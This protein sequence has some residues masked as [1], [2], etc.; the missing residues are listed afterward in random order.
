MTNQ[1]K[2]VASRII[3][4]PSCKKTTRYDDSNEFRPFCCE[5]CQIID[6]G[7]WAD[8]EYR[9]PVKPSSDDFDTDPEG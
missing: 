2:Q 1:S 9:V 4:C 7:A 8:E 5:R 3:N 6:T